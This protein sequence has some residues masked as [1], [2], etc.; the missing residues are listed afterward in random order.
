MQM[1]NTNISSADKR[2]KLDTKDIT[3]ILK[4]LIKGE[5][6]KQIANNFGVDQ[7]RVAQLWAKKRDEIKNKYETGKLKKEVAQKFGLTL[8]EVDKV[9]QEYGD[10]VNFTPIYS[11]FW[12][13]FGTDKR[14]D[15]K[16]PDNFQL[17]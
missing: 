7:S 1:H 10:P 11:S 17:D 6:Q 15:Q 8:E 2:R 3:A 14:Y 13:S 12:P 4:L 9:L 5:S 16:H